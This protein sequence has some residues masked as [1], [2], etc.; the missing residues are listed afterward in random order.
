MRTLA[1]DC[2]WH[3]WDMNPVSHFEWRCAAPKSDFP[4]I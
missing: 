4:I 3:V 1:F 2:S